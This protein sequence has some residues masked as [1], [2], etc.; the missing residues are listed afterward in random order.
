MKRLY[1]RIDDW[2]GTLSPEQ[3]RRID[4]LVGDAPFIHRL[5]YEDRRRRQREFLQL[6]ASRGS[7]A[8]AFTERLRHFLAN[9]EEGRDPE[10]DRLYKDWEQRQA[11]L[12][13]AVYKMLT[14]QQRALALHRLQGYIDDF[15]QISRRPAER[16]P[17]RS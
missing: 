5:R 11:D 4:A 14:P 3:E 16:A 13:V 12:Y 7:D 15:T 10:Y 17:A 2:T 6:M 9:W 1:S 8:R